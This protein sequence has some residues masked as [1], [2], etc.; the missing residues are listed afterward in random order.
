MKQG[1]I[2]VL[3]GCHDLVH[4]FLVWHSWRLLYGRWPQPWQVGCIFL[5]DIGH[6][7][8]NYLD[9]ERE[10]QKHWEGGAALAYRLFGKRGYDLVAGHCSNSGFPTSDLARPDKYSWYIAPYWWLWCNNVVEPQLMAGLSNRAAILDFRLKVKKSIE[11][12]EFASTHSFYLQRV[13]G[14]PK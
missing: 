11:S 10:K 7:G 6:W 14:G 12:G 8:K 1:T 3:C 2:S 9:D 13:Q 5:H 4:S